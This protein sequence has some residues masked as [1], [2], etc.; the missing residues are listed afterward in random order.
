MN[1]YS[2]STYL[3]S[4]LFL[5][6]GGSEAIK[7]NICLASYASLHSIVT[8]ESTRYFMKIGELAKLSGCSIQ[9]IRYY[10]TQQLL[11]AVERSEGN[12]RLYNK[13]TIK[14][15]LFIKQCRSLDLSLTEIRQL[16]S[17]RQD[18]DNSCN[19]VNSMINAHI[20]QVEHRINQLQGLRKELKELSIS[21]S[22]NKAV[23]ECGILKNI[24]AHSSLKD[25]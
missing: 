11:F 20:E 21:C 2:I 12:F 24:T 10:E 16:I 23:N 9:T 17:L 8:I 19:S 14:Q 6:Q 22:T 5:R 3:N 25:S 13:Q 18:A 7:N 1:R 15:L 4:L